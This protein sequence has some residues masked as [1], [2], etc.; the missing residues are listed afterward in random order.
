MR[1]SESTR[2]GPNSLFGLLTPDLRGFYSSVTPLT[3]V[4]IYSWPVSATFFFNHSECP[5]YVPSGPRRNRPVKDRLKVQARR[6]HEEA[7]SHPVWTHCRSFHRQRH[8]VVADR[9]A[10]TGPE[11]Q[12]S[13]QH[14]HHRS[15][16]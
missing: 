12:S 11:I 16:Q 3:I 14:P 2:A 1:P 6:D 4:G 13:R 9:L 10:C 8:F 7:T 15:V 5:S